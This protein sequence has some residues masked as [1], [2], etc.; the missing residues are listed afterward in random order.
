MQHAIL[1]VVIIGMHVPQIFV[2][3]WKILHF[4]GKVLLN[5]ELFILEQEVIRP[6]LHFIARRQC[7]FIGIKKFCFFHSLC[8]NTFIFL[9]VYNIFNIG[10]YKCIVSYLYINLTVSYYLFSIEH[11]ITY[12]CV[13]SLLKYHIYTLLLVCTKIFRNCK[14][15]Q[16]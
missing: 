6:N 3:C 10:I 14:R 11:F 13:F 2:C 9:Q 5:T 4:V 8:G 16:C 12:H 15:G 1:H 7:R